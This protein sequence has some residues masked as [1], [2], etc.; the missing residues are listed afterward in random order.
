[1]GAVSAA[2]TSSLGPAERLVEHRCHVLPLV[3]VCGPEHEHVVL[4]R[5]GV[6]V[7]QHHVVG[8]REVARVIVERLGVQRRLLE[9]GREQRR[10]V[11]LVERRDGLG[12]VPWRRRPP[13]RERVGLLQLTRNRQR[14]DVA[15][16]SGG[17][18][19]PSATREEQY[20]GEM[21]TI[22]TPT[23]TPNL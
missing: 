23:P 15:I 2:R 11:L 4:D 19:G 10:S 6:Q 18:P 9:M 16:V 21:T 3:S 1:M 7:V 5:L 22:A 14:Q 13:G 12:V 17:E 8:D 20:G